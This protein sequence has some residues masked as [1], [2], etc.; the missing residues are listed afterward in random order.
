M[1]I[2]FLEYAPCW[3]KHAQEQ[4]KYNNLCNDRMHRFLE[5]GNSF[6]PMLSC[7]G[8]GGC[9]KTQTNNS[10]E[11]YSTAVW[12]VISYLFIV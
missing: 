5:C 9:F 12:I 1:K 7:A 11:K 8:K 3:G 6:S 2:L 4:L 10:I